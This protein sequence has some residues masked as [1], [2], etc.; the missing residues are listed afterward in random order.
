SRGRSPHPLGPAVEIELMSLAGRISMPS[1]SVLSALLLLW[2][3]GLAWGAETEP[4]RPAVSNVPPL[5]VEIREWLQA[6]ES[7]KAIEAI[8]QQLA[9]PDAPAPDYLLYQK[10]R[11]LSRLERFDEAL[12]VFKLLEEKYPQSRWLSRARF[13]Q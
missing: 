8:D 10:G 11:A 9:K 5:P 2:I 3:G 6:D 7:A 4:S 12:A 13:G 1:R